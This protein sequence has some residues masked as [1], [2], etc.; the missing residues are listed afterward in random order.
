MSRTAGAASNDAVEPRAIHVGIVRPARR[1]GNAS[2]VPA[3]RLRGPVPAGN[4]GR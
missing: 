1:H 3:D 2:V 4:G